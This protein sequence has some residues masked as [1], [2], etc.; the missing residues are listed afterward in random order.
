[1]V[2]IS[3]GRSLSPSL[4]PAF[5]LCIYLSAF[6]F[7]LI[8]SLVLFLSLYAYLCERA[9]LCSSIYLFIVVSVC[10]RVCPAVYLF[11]YLFVCVSKP[12]FIFVT[13]LRANSHPSASRTKN[14]VSSPHRSAAIANCYSVDF[15]NPNPW[16][17]LRIS[18][19]RTR[20]IWADSMSR[21]SDHPSNRIPSRAF[22]T[23]TAFIGGDFGVNID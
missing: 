8:L 19:S 12:P 10:A 7:F 23:A 6:L 1:M 15:M 2:S 11:I 20:E 18:S 3:L 13:Y 5:S 17:R 22:P 21:R 14:F 16:G 4:S 9:C